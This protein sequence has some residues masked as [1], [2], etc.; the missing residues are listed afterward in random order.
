MFTRSAT[1]TA[2]AVVAIATGLITT[3]NCL[4]ALS[5]VPVTRAISRDAM[6]KSYKPLTVTVDEDGKKVKYTGVPLRVVFQEML[7]EYKLQSMPQWKELARKNLVVEVVGSDGYPGL[8]TALE[9]AM[10]A[11]G[12]R[13]ILAT[14]RNGKPNEKGVQLI[15]KM[16]QAHVRWVREIVSLRVVAVPAATK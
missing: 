14:D 11:D 2:L 7:P 8:V 9:L 4:V 10:N 15:C 5:D 3:S 16:D 12:D 6:L 1:K 13:F